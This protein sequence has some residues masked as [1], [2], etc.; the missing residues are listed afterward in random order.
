MFIFAQ[1]VEN[2][3]ENY[4]SKKTGSTDDSN[5]L[6]LSKVNSTAT[7]LCLDFFPFARDGAWRRM[8]FSDKNCVRIK[9][10]RNN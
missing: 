10:A 4:L 1:S 3:K 8:A 5:E 9:D 6:N 2:W 7:S